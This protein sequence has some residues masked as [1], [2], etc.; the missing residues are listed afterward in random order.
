MSAQKGQGGNSTPAQGNPNGQAGQPSPAQGDLSSAIDQI[1]NVSSKDLGPFGKGLE[2]ILT[3]N[4]KALSRAPMI[5]CSCCVRL[6]SLLPY[7]NLFI[8]MYG[9]I[10]FRIILR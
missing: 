5:S 8:N 7:S 9:G 1:L 4:T 10:R 6:N 2:E 3:A